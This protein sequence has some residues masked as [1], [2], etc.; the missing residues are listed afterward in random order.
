MCF[1]CHCQLLSK[2]LKILDLD[3]CCF[4]IVGRFISINRWESLCSRL[5]DHSH[6]ALF[7]FV[8]CDH[9]CTWPRGS[10]ISFDT[11]KFI[12]C[13]YNLKFP[14]SSGTIKKCLPSG[15]TEHWRKCK[16]CSSWN[17]LVTEITFHQF[18]HCRGNICQ[19]SPLLPLQHIRHY[20]NNVSNWTVMRLI[21]SGIIL[22]MFNFSC[23]ETPLDGKDYHRIRESKL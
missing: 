2:H 16:F 23:Q 4:W 15:S 7:V 17:I 13:D 18:F 10:W 12:I 8:K 20:S 11:W 19:S 22:G 14:S 3:N 5:R 6:Q 21:W 9:S 1:E